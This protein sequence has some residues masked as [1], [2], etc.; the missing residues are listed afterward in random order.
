MS[1]TCTVAR[2]VGVDPMIVIPSQRK[3]LDQDWRRG[4][5]RE[6]FLP[7]KGSRADRRADL[8]SEHETQASARL[9][10]SVE[11]PQARGVM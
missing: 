4:W 5:K 8:R 10:G 11:P 2:P 1:S 6:T 3:C 9:S 7:V